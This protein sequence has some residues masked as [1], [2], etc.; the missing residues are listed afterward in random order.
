[1]YG[2]T[3]AMI[4]QTIS[5]YKILEKL[6]GGGMGIVYKARDLKLD[7]DVALKCLPPELT[8]DLEAKERFIHEARAAS[9]LQHNNICTVH[10]IDETADRQLFIVMDCYEGETLKSRIAKARMR[11]EDAAEVAIQVAQGL[12]KAHEKGIVHRDIKPA[13]IMITDDGIA[14]ILDFGLAKLAHQTKLT[15]GGATLGTF[16]YMSPE[17]TRGD[18]VDHRTDIWSLGVV[19]Y[20][21]LTGQLPFKGDYENAV[22]YS[23]LNLHQAPIAGLCT[24]VPT[25]LERIVEKALAKNPAERY[26]HADDLMADLRTV[27]RKLET[28]ETASALVG[29]E[30][31]KQRPW[32]LYAGLAV[33]V[34]AAILAVVLFITPTQAP[35]DSIAVLPF[36]NLSAD[37]E[38]EYFSDG[39]TEALITE[40]S[41]IQALRVISRTSVMPYKKTDKSLPQIAKELNVS[42]V[43]EGSVQRVQDDVRIT[44]QLVAAAPERHLWANTF[45]KSYRNI[46]VLQS[47]VAQA[48]AKEI[49]VTVTP[50]EQQRLASARPVR[51]EAYEAYLKGRFFVDKFTESDIRRGISFFEQA[52][53]ADS[54]YA[55]AYAG[56]AEGYDYLWSLGVMSSKDAFPKIKT[57]AM[58][59]LS[60]DG[61]LSEAYAIIGDVETAEWNWQGAEE[62][63]KKAV[64]LNQN[65]AT[66]HLYYSGYLCYV[67]R[68]DEA[69]SECKKAL[70][71]DPLSLLTRFMLAYSYFFKHEYDSAM[72]QVNEI[73]SIDSNAIG[74]YRALGTFSMWKGNSKEAI[75]HFGKAVALGDYPALAFLAAAYAR[76]GDVRKAREILAGLKTR[77]IQPSLYVIVYMEL[78]EVD[79]AFERLE[80][81][82]LEN[83]PLWLNVF[84]DLPT[85][86]DANLDRFRKDPR[87][88]ALITKMGLKE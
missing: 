22:V 46:L 4:G 24:G 45:T 21:M 68:F 26:Q 64:A 70:A 31:V 44:A 39:V 28:G 32:Y 5:H 82:Y 60:I 7:R 61:T 2:R 85:G 79:H 83:D 52:I 38:Q 62:S 72:T 40:L 36:Q 80:R 25:E 59:A 84:Y 55:L 77:Y 12:Q 69:L 48:I 66:A 58:K 43:I 63:Y 33:I 49:R 13:N 1:L 88:R 41:R 8:L 71:V 9:A 34:V 67:R 10:D 47:E 19:L 54:S 27:K 37:P 3:K 15:K 14:K 81:A 86:V 57:L 75:A 53:A 73:L 87:F 16:A 78:G 17:Q 23:I 51:P 76:S 56:L 42:A 29:H 74:G 35:L 11:I 65:N 6:G 18:Q 50:E 20:E 30:E